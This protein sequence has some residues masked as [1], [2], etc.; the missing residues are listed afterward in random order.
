MRAARL[1]ELIV[2]KI[3]KTNTETQVYYFLDEMQQGQK[4][5][6]NHLVLITEVCSG[7]PPSLFSR[8]EMCALF[9]IDAA[10]APR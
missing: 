1:A 3:T 6:F 5:C 8:S 7:R 2:V 9:T 4:V 10:D